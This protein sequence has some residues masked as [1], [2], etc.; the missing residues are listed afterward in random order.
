M[1]SFG[2]KL[3]LLRKERGLSIVQLMNE[4]KI[5]KTSISRCERGERQPNLDEIVTLAKFFNV[6]A[7]Y[8]CGLED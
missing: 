1:S 8:L 2:D 7:D 3:K 6:S 5:D 4:T